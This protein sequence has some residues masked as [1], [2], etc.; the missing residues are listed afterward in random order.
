[1]PKVLETSTKTWNIE[2]QKLAQSA[3]TDLNGCLLI[4]LIKEN[5][6]KN[7]IIQWNQKF[8]VTADLLLIEKLKI[9]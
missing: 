9:S 7:L 6:T 4:P 1:M 3:E 8:G 2:K 5:L